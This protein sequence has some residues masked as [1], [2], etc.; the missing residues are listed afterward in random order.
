MSDDFA[1]KGFGWSF[2][3][4]VLHRTGCGFSFKVPISQNFIA[5]FERPQLPSV[6]SAFGVYYPWSAGFWLSFSLPIQVIYFYTVRKGRT[7]GE[8][9][10]EGGRLKPNGTRRAP[11]D[12]PPIDAPPI[13]APPIDAPLQFRSLAR[14]PSAGRKQPAE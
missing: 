9:R 11:I 6:Q 3:K 5:C 8:K 13:D 14:S 10:D 12:A 4:S 2:Y 7:G 1:F